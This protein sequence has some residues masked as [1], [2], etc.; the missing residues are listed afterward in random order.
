MPASARFE[1]EEQIGKTLNHP[2]VLKIIPVEEQ[3]SR[4]Y[5]VMEFLE[6]RTLAD[7]LKEVKPLPEADAVADCQPHL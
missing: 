1:R 5:I 6:G 3:K 2:S 7:L 4:P